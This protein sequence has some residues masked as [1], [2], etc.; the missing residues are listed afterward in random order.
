MTDKNIVKFDDSAL[1]LFCNT[2]S[3]HHVQKCSCDPD[4]DAYATAAL[5]TSDYTCNHVQKLHTLADLPCMAPLARKPSCCMMAIVNHSKADTQG[6]VVTL[7]R[8]SIV[9]KLSRG[10]VSLFSLFQLLYGRN[11]ACRKKWAIQRS[12]TLYHVSPA[13]QPK[14]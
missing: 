1:Q 5:Q 2:R 11:W 13:T 8:C 4:P 14:A 6:G 3:K 12:T 7:L 10:V 9:P